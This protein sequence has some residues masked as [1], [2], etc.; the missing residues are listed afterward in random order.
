MNLNKKSLGIFTGLIALVGSL[1]NKQNITSVEV[2]ALIV[3]FFVLYMLY[4]K[5]DASSRTGQ[6]NWDVYFTRFFYLICLGIFGWGG[7]QML[8]VY[9]TY[10]SN[11]S[12]KIDKDTS[13]TKKIEDT[14]WR[15]PLEVKLEIQKNTFKGQI[16][17]LDNQIKQIEKQDP[18]ESTFQLDS[19]KIEL[20]HK[21]L[22]IDS[23]LKVVVDTLQKNKVLNQ[24]FIQKIQSK[25]D[26]IMR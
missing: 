23:L 20:S 15:H 22:G 14:T 5:V 10:L 11:D 4:T 7:Y 26:E 19:S 8:S 12:V 25:Y 13:Q 17:N 16:T 24:P 2:C 9:P 18:N 3:V 21:V 6:S 1:L